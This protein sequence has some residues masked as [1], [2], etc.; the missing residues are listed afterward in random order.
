[1]KD[2]PNKIKKIII[3]NKEY[4][5]IKALLSEIGLLGLHKLDSG[6]IT[7]ALIIGQLLGALSSEEIYDVYPKKSGDG[8]NLVQLFD[9]ITNKE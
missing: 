8:D 2:Q 5:D 1:M 6:D 4:V 9:S 7:T 3:N